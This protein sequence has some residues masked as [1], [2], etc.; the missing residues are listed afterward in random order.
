MSGDAIVIIEDNEDLRDEIVDY[1]RRRGRSAVG[2][3]TLAEAQ[4]VC[5]Q[6]S[7]AVVVADIHL[8]DGD[9]VSFCRDMAERYPDIKWVL[10]SGNADLVRQG[11]QARTS[12]FAV[13]DKPIPLRT[14][15]RFVADA[16]VRRAR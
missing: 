14:L 8:P 3:R 1:L 15:D 13:I 4:D 11:N 6:Q 9:G 12:A 2:C 16:T 7:P 5:R 10:M